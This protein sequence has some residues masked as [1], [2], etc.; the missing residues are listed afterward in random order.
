MGNITKKQN[1]VEPGSPSL[2]STQMPASGNLFQMM[3]DKENVYNNLYSETTNR[4]TAMVT[5]LCVWHQS[6]F[7]LIWNDLLIYLVIYFL[8]SIFYRNVL[9]HYPAYKQ[10]FEMICIYADR[11]SSSVPITFLVGFWVSKVV[12]RWW[13]QFMALPMPDILALKLV[14]FLP[15]TVSKSWYIS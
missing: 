6:V 2:Q 15:G 11:F 4:W 14:A 9:W 7:K 13:D 10:A 5:L 3:R 8:M 1:N 12:D